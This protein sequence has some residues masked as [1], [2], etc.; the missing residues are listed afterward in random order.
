MV[1]AARTEYSKLEKP[2][3]EFKYDTDPKQSAGSRVRILDMLAANK[4]PLAAYH[5]P[6]PGYGHI[7]KNGDGFLDADEISAM[8]RGPRPGGAAP[9]GQGQSA[10]GG[11]NGE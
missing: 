1:C 4:I 6:W 8:P 9:G 3:T 10:I 7:V 2:L 5:F 11:G